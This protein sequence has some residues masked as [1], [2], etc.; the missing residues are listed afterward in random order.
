M[1]DSEQRIFVSHVAG[2]GQTVLAL[3]AL[4]ALRHYF[5]TAHITVAASNSA[6]EIIQ[7]SRTADEVLPVFRRGEIIRP[8]NSYRSLKSFK[9]IRRQQFDLTLELKRNPVGGLARYLAQSGSST[10]KIKLLTQ[11][12][13][14]ILQRGLKYK[15]AAQAYLEILAEV[16]A[17]PIDTAPKLFTDR[18]ADQRIDLRLSKHDFSSGGLLVGIHP[19]AGKN[20]LRWATEKFAVV[21]AK[22]IHTMDARVIIFAGP[23]ERG[24]AKH[25]TQQLPAKK[26]LALESLSLN[27]LASA[28]A[29]LSVF[30]TNH[31]GPAHLAAAVGA[32]VVVTSSSDR[33]LDKLLSPN[34]LQIQQNSIESIT[35]DEVFEAACQLIQASR[36]EL[37]WAR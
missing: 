17:Y 20:K 35:T 27:D 25:L 8:R 29:R 18:E 31:S 36:A 7:L 32:P 13:E 4:R 3:P 16:G 22:L 5:P 2:I 21:A 24:L 11:L 12:R 10:K 6:F 34:H 30:I 37:L 28:T 14:A 9:A 15:H 26:S 1:A 19:G 33:N 23:N